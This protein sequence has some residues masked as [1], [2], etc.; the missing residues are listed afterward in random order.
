MSMVPQIEKQLGVLT[1]A[2]LQRPLGMPRSSTVPCSPTS[3]RQNPT[4]F[5][6]QGAALNPFACPLRADND[7]ATPSSTLEQ[8]FRRSR[9]HGNRADLFN[10]P[11]GTQQRATAEWKTLLPLTAGGGSFTVTRTPGRRPGQQLYT[12]ETMGGGEGEGR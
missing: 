9:F 1:R 11:I 3:L 10:P 4:S 12:R 7:H 5:K 2:R 8:S 6:L